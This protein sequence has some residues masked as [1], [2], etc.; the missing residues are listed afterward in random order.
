MNKQGE[1]PKKLWLRLDVDNPVAYYAGPLNRLMNRIGFLTPFKPLYYLHHVKLTQELLKNY[2]IPR[3]WFFRKY[4]CPKSFDEPFGAHI[5]TP[6]E[7]EETIKLLEKRIGKFNFFTRHGY[8]AEI[9]PGRIWLKREIEEVERRYGLKDLSDY[10]HIVVKEYNNESLDLFNLN[11]ILFHPC[12]IHTHKD[13]LIK[14]LDKA[15]T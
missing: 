4:T 10:N 2:E 8:N 13:V 3:I 9:K 15:T 5:G 11:H 6:E 7:S 14:I 1:L 12:Y